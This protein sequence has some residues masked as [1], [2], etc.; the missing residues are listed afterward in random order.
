MFNGIEPKIKRVSVMRPVMHVFLVG[1]IV[2]LVSVLYGFS[3]SKHLYRMV[4]SFAATF[5]DDTQSEFD[6]GTYAQTQW[7]AGNSWAELNTTGLTTNNNN[8][9]S[10]WTP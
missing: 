5:S 9:D 4:E 8:L 2:A 10:S 6:A 3:D 1:F 7:D